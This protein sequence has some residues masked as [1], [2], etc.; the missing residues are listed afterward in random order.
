METMETKQE[1]PQAKT[2]TRK[3]NQVEQ[4]RVLSGLR[5]RLD[6]HDE[7]RR[8]VQTVSKLRAKASENRQRHLKKG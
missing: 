7:S 4:R 2:R 6:E 8:S 5:E 3:K 1:Q